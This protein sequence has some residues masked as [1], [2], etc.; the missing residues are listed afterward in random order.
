MEDI[1]MA[2]NNV[3]LFDDGEIITLHDD[4]DKPIDF[5][6][7]ACVDYEGNFYAL[8]RPKDAVDGIAEDEVVI[9]KLQEGKEND[10]FVPVES[11][12]LLNKVFEQYVKAVAD[13]NS[14]GCGCG[15]SS[16][17]DCGCQ[18]GEECD[19]NDDCG[20]GCDDDCN[21]KED[22]CDCGCGGKTKK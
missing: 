20:C 14:C 1:T 18:E 3:E 2:D 6:Q 16:D 15:C 12:E 19:C 11:E 22:A 7:V 5:I 10:L 13:D 21:D 9:F 4:K 17:C 8:L